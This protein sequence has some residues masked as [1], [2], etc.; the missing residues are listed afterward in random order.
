MA[1]K[2][3]AT[4]KPASP[5]KKKAPKKRAKRVS[6]KSTSKR[7]NLPDPKIEERRA[8][9]SEL[10]LQGWTMGRIAD[11]LGHSIGTVSTDLKACREEWQLQRLENVDELITVE[12]A[13]IAKIEAAAWDGWFR[14]CED[15]TN[16]KDQ[17]V[18]FE[19]TITDQWVQHFREGQAGDPRFLK[20]A[21]DCV[22]RRCKLLGLDAD[23]AN[24]NQGGPVVVEVVVT[25]RDE[26]QQLETFDAALAR[27]HAQQK[28]LETSADGNNPGS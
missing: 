4:K 9:V 22:D 8:R 1:K 18:V 26:I 20:I 21:Q 15:K 13:K 3:A 19:G 7:A 14:S 10:Y 27:R 6:N 24:R 11:D 5:K 25:S 12:L 16:C 23:T 17:V 2:K 28:L